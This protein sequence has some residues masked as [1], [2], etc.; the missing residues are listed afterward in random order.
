[1]QCRTVTANTDSAAQTQFVPDGCRVP[2]MITES[3][4]RRLLDNC[5]IYVHYYVERPKVI[6]KFRL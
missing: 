1:M 6:P 4:G 5:S 3:A 2:D